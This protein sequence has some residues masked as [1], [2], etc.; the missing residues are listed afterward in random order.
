MTVCL[1]E[2]MAR[3]GIPYLAVAI[4]AAG[5]SCGVWPI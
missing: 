3:E 1:A 5:V 4:Y 2:G